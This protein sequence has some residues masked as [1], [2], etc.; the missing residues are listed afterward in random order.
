MSTS[1]TYLVRRTAVLACAMLALLFML[2]AGALAQHA[3]K[4]NA[5]DDVAGVGASGQQVAVDANTG[6][7]RKPTQE[8]IQQLI[9]GLKIND[10]AEGLQAHRVGNNALV[11]DLEG[12]FENVM[13]A[14][15]NSD[16]TLSKAC[17]VSAQ[18]AEDFLKSDTTKAQPQ[19]KAKSYPSTWEVK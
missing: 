3:A 17:V 13:V 16:G 7:L 19:Q 8:E 5:P 10:S 18:Q 6:K 9:T 1:R 12:R 4:G 15:I 11:M 14:K 2:S